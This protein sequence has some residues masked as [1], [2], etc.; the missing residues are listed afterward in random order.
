MDAHSQCAYIACPSLSLY[1]LIRHDGVSFAH[2]A[3]VPGREPEAVV[4]QA[5]ALGRARA[6]AVDLGAAAVRRTPSTTASSAGR[7]RGT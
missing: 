5:R 1:K 6:R 2:A 7:R 3:V 4:V